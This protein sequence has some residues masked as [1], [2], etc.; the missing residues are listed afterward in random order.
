MANTCSICSHNDRKSID[1]DLIGS[2]SLRAIAGRYDV[3]SSSLDRHRRNCLAP[4]VASAIARREE[5]SAD[6]LVSYTNGLL[7]YALAG[8]L[9]ARQNDDEF[10]VRSYMAES[11][12]NIELLAK[13][14]HLI[15]DRGPVVHVDARR[16]VAV[17]ANLSEEDLRALARGGDVIEAQAR[18][19]IEA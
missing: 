7:D 6:R 17:L 5:V 4:K 2:D 11:R 18:E 9:R 10:G 14:G 19:A 3:S 8:M 13:L 12:K 16:Q 15:G 1:R